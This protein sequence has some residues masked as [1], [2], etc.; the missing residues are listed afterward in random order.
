MTRLVCLTAWRAPVR[1]HRLGFA[2]D[3]PLSTCRHTVISAVDGQLA[4]I[5]TSD[6]C[7]PVAVLAADRKPPAPSMA[8]RRGGPVALTLCNEAP[9]SLLR[10]FVGFGPKHAVVVDG[11]GVESGSGKALRATDAGLRN[12]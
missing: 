7:L 6:P 12:K 4:A 9:T 8:G 5:N 1:T 3:T 2:S 11:P 10:A